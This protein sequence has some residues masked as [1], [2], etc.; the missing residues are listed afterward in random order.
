MRDVLAEIDL[1]VRESYADVREL[2]VNFRTRAS[3][4]TSGPPCRP[5]C[6]SSSSTAA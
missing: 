1:G 3:E 4:K 2:L 5:R 6:A